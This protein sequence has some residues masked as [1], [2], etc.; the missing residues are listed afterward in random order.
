MKTIFR[1]QRQEDRGFESS[2]VLSQKQKYKQKGWGLAQVVE[3]CLACMRPWAQS[4][5][6]EEKIKE[7]KISWS[8]QI[9]SVLAIV[10]TI[11]PSLLFLIM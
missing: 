3:S 2:L 4:P 1:W 6:A 7:R 10:S 5:I 11:L 8:L 9:G